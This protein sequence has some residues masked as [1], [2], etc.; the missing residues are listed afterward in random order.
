MYNDAHACSQRSSGE[1]KEGYAHVFP[2]GPTVKL[3]S[4]ALRRP[5]AAQ[6]TSLTTSSLGLSTSCAAAR[7]AASSS[8]T[9]LSPSEDGGRGCGGQ[10]GDGAHGNKDARSGGEAVA[11]E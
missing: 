11:E 4:S 10:G 5:S 9:P 1:K 7:T 3:P 6:N 2:A 8:P